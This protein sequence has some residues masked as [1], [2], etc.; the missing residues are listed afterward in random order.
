[1]NTRQPISTTIVDDTP[2]WQAIVALAYG[3]GLLAAIIITA[4]VLLDAL[5]LDERA[6]LALAA[7]KQVGDATRYYKVLFLIVFWVD[8]G[9][10]ITSGAVSVSAMLAAYAWRSV[11]AALLPAGPRVIAAPSRREELRR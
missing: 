8:L 4:A 6:R 1:M 11:R 2:K 5:Q 7:A 3:F 9:I 10:V